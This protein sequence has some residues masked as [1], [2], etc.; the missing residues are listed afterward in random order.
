M[1]YDDEMDT[2]H[3]SFELT[4]DNIRPPTR[5]ALAAYKLR[6]LGTRKLDEPGSLVRRRQ[7][8]DD[9]PEKSWRRQVGHVKNM[10]ASPGLHLP[11]ES[12]LL[13]QLFRAV[14]KCR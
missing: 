13:V 8:Y 12:A 6:F 7:K 2:S 11:P 9:F 4:E 3:G 5:A 10:S 14:Q 1:E